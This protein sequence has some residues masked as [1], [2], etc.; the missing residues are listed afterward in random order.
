M[1]FVPLKFGM[2]SFGFATIFT[3]RCKNEVNISDAFR[4]SGVSFTAE[5]IKDLEGSWNKIESGSIREQ[6]EI[7]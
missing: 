1:C 4:F 5:S 7:F 6:K 3:V 2:G